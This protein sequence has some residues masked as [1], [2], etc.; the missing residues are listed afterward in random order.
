MPEYTH[1]QLTAFILKND[2][3]TVTTGT[4]GDAFPLRNPIKY[5]GPCIIKV[6]GIATVADI[7]AK[8][9]FDG[10]LVTE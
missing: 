5:A 10:Y 2:M 4:S 8:A 3:Y 1:E 6:Q 7:D 9:A